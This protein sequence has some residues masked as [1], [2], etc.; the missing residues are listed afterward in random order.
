MIPDD[1][2]QEDRVDIESRRLENVIRS[3]SFSYLGLSSEGH[4]ER[5]IQ[6]GL[7]NLHLC[8]QGRDRVS[9]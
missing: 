3:V 5:K 7:R 9:R 1:A 6:R 8:F 2:G 4:D